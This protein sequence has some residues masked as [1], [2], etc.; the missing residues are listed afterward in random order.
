MDIKTNPWDDIFKE[1]GRF[2]NHPHADMPGIVNLL[3]ERKA[4][5]VLDLGN[6]T[7]RHTVYLAQNGF[8][9]YGMDNS[10]QATKSA[11][12]W[13]QAEGLTADLK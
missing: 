4:S 9:V 12:E 11:Q 5:A 13:L 2:F 6:G 7:G 3:K 1:K 10:P 8:K